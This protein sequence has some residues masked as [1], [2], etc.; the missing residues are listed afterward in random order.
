MIS[1]LYIDNYNTHALLYIIFMF[2]SVYTSGQQAISFQAT[3][4]FNVNPVSHSTPCTE[5]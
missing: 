2:F 1:F 4:I 5:L 3:G